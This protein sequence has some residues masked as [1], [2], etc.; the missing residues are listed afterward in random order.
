MQTERVKKNDFWASNPI[1]TD[2]ERT[3][4]LGG[5]GKNVIW[6]KS[7]G[8]PSSRVWTALTAF[9]EPIWGRGKICPGLLNGYLGILISF[10]G[11]VVDL[12]Q[13]TASTLGI[14]LGA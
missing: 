11:G 10:L 9:G 5:E 6:R 7:R 3:V 8:L 4:L 2:D 13:N 14:E 12:I 1:K